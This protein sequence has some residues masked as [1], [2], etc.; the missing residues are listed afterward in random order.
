MKQSQTK[1]ASH[2]DN[3]RKERA[4]QLGG[5]Q[6][7]LQ[8]K[9]EQ[10]DTPFSPQRNVGRLQQ[11]ATWKCWPLPSPLPSPKCLS[12]AST[13]ASTAASTAP[14]C[15]ATLFGPRTDVG[16]K[17]RHTDATQTT[18][19]TRG[20]EAA[21]KRE[22]REGH[23]GKQRE[24][25]TQTHAHALKNH[26][27]ARGFPWHTRRSCWGLRG[28]GFM[29]NRAKRRPAFYERGTPIKKKATKRTPLPSAAGLGR[30]PRARRRSP[31]APPRRRGAGR[32]GRR[33]R[34]G[35][36]WP[37]PTCRVGGAWGCPWRLPW[38]Q[39]A[40]WARSLHNHNHKKESSSAS[41]FRWF[42]IRG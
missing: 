17:E 40:T 15:S 28:A 37:P 25:H 29:Q 6:K 34:L 16:S 13:Q 1:P 18:Q 2:A 42:S 14:W 23:A 24:T 30:D 38:P 4:G 39:P 11:F 26:N 31:A 27:A 8:K 19:D 22:A 33:Y 36:R 5:I 7:F 10:H 35:R 21:T 32:L 41:E 3:P 20:A 9:T 12:Q